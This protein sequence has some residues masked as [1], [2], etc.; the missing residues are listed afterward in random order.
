MGCI[1]YKTDHFSISN[2]FEELKSDKTLAVQKV[3][4]S[5][6]MELGKFLKKSEI[7]LVTRAQ[8]IYFM[9]YIDVIWDQQSIGDSLPDTILQ[10]LA[11]IE[12]SRS[13]N[14]RV[15]CCTGSSFCDR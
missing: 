12:Y 6:Y 10:K 11:L 1:L 13:E 2:L 4:V 14:V 7:S 3:N 9:L 5:L 15:S 8:P